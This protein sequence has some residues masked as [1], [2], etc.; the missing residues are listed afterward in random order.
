MIEIPAIPAVPPVATAELLAAATL[1]W[2]GFNI[3]R[4]LRDPRTSPAEGVMLDLGLGLI[5][6]AAA[7]LWLSASAMIL[8]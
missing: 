2:I 8:F 4:T 7:V 5:T 1:S 6:V 3:H